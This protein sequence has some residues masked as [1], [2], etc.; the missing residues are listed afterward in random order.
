M[1]GQNFCVKKILGQKNVGSKNIWGKKVGT[2]QFNV[3]VGWPG[4]PVIIVP[5]C[6]LSCK[7]RLARFSAELKDFKIDQVWQ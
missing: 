1:L 4:L 6:G 2:Q 3:G 5:L 7:Q